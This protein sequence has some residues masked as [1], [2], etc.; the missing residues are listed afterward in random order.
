MK[1]KTYTDHDYYNFLKEFLEMNLLSKSKTIDKISVKEK[2]LSK[3]DR[4]HEITTNKCLQLLENEG[5]DF[6][7]PNQFKSIEKIYNELLK[8][9]ENT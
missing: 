1:Y 4:I 6:K 5:I 2:S 9:T 7:D 8:E 3:Y